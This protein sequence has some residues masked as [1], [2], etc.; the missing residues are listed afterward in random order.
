[1]LEASNWGQ[2]LGRALLAAAELEPE[3]KTRGR[4]A[5]Q[6]GRVLACVLRLGEATSAQV[7][8]AADMEHSLACHHLSELVKCRE[9][10][11]TGTRCNYR[12]RLPEAS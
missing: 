2:V 10:G 6:R 12:Y 1:M 5:P 3:K 4:P 9:L 11:R 8:A 7:A